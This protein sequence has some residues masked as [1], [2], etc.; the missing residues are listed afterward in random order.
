MTACILDS[1]VAAVKVS[2]ALAAKRV[3]RLPAP[4]KAVKAITA[5]RVK[6]AKSSANPSVI[7]LPMVKL[8]NDMVGWIAGEVDEIGVS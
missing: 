8:R 3:N 6:R 2:S 4:P 5:T 1:S 7:F